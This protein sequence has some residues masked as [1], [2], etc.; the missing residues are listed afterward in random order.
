MTQQ[1]P[2]QQRN[3]D[4][5][6]LGKAYDP[7]IVSRTWV[8]VRPYRGRM[9]LAVLLMICIAVANLAQ[10]YLVKVAIDQAIANADLRLLTLTALGYV[11][12]ALVSWGCTYDQTYIMSWVG[13]SVLFSMRR[14]LFEHL[15][16][17][18]FSF[19]DTMEAGRI[20]SRMTGDV[21]S[22]NDF[23]TSG[24]VAVA[25]SV[26]M[27]VGIVAIMFALNWQ[28]ALIT[29]AVIPVIAVATHVYRSRSRS[30]YREV[31][32]QNSIV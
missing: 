5:E 19:Y 28:L 29:M 25:S 1:P 8:Y 16:R 3:P 17:L 31:R 2:S 32:E 23:L 10:P 11:V 22:L 27:L 13:Q 7:K 20:M 12:C 6:V 21:N 24:I 4:N 15:Q 14:E 9:L 18:S 30:L 26:F